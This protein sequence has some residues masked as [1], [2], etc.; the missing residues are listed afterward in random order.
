MCQN[1]T[2]SDYPWFYSNLRLKKIEKG[3]AIPDK[4]AQ[5]EQENQVE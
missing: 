1:G 3:E 5:H 2:F 4:I